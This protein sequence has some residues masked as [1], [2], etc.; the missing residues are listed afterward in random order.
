MSIAAVLL[1]GLGLSSI[2]AQTPPANSVSVFILLL[3]EDVGF[4]NLPD[5]AA[6]VQEH[7]VWADNLGKAGQ[8]V[9]AARIKDDGMTSGSKNTRKIT[10]AELPGKGM[11]VARYFIIRAADAMEASKIASTCPH[12]RY[13]GV[14]SVREL[15]R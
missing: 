7:R 3:H 2:F 9:D 11:G 4:K 8:L 12:I 14:V 5:K 15:E 1:G 10:A 6:Q 13:G